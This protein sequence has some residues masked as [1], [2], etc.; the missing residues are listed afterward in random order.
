[1]FVRHAR[2]PACAAPDRSRTVVP[3]P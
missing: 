2:L 1:L 3:T